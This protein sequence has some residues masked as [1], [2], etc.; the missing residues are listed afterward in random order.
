MDDAVLARA[1]EPFYSTKPSARGLGLAAVEGIV[2]GHSGAIDLHS[3]IGR[4]TTIRVYLPSL[5]EA[6]RQ[7]PEHD[8]VEVS[9]DRWQ[10]SGRILVADD[11]E[12]VRRVAGALL[13][14]FGFDVLSARTGDEAIELLRRPGPTIAAVLLDFTMPGPTSDETLTAIRAMYPSL[15]VLL[16]SGYDDD[17][18]MGVVERFAHTMYLPKPYRPATLRNALRQMLR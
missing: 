15:P 16:S 4:G 7:A 12:D 5:D 14:R 18:V 11:E 17:R 10:G 6:M 13:T 9:A 2:R 8:T 3:K 1:F